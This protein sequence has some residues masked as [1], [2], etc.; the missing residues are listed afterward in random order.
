MRKVSYSYS[1]T[2]IDIEYT[3]LLK[4][5]KGVIVVVFVV[6]QHRQM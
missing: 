4:K 3:G 2:R 1:G 6:N 5:S